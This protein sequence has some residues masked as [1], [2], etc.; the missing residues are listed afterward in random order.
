MLKVMGFSCLLFAQS[1]SYS[2]QPI[3]PRQP[4]SPSALLTQLSIEEKIGQLFIATCII[5]QKKNA[6]IVAYKNYATDIETVKKYINDYHIGGIIFLGMDTVNPQ[7][8][9][10]QEFQQL[11]QIPLFI[12]MDF[13]RG[14]NCGPTMRLYDAPYFPYNMT[15]GALS[16]DQLIY[17]MAAEIAREGKILGVH[18][19]FAPVADVNNN[20]LNPAINDRSFGQ[21]PHKVAQKAIVYM[22]GLQDNG[23]IACAK[24][25]PG[26]GDVSKDSHHELPQVTHDEKRLHA[27]ELYPFKQ[28]IN[29][30]VKMIMTA[31]LE[32]PAL[33]SQPKM[34]AALS[35]NIVTH[36]LKEQL[37]FQGLIV[38]DGLDMTGVTQ[39]GSDQE[40]A[41]QALLAGNDLLLCSRNIPAAVA[42]I[43]KAIEDGR[44]TLQELDA[45]V[46]K[47]LRAKAWVFEQHA[48]DK[49]TAAHNL[50]SDKAAQLKKKLFSQSITIAQDHAKLI[51]LPS[52]S[53]TVITLSKSNDASVF[54]QTLGTLCE[55]KEIIVTDQNRNVLEQIKSHSSDIII[56]NMLNMARFAA[57]NFGITQST[58]D[59]LNVVRSTGKK[60]IFV[61][62][63]NPYSLKNF[64]AQDIVIIGYENDVDAQEAAARIIMGVMPARG[65]LP[66]TC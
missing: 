5:D 56:V 40:I 12:A 22:Q 37:D 44:L 33:D 36:L 14:L 65:T 19:N 53:C 52:T 21:D 6:A 10:T 63:G 49:A 35:K 32:V 30:N 18:I 2:M 27:V 55:V 47:I 64:D 39:Y 24:H 25:F 8:Q 61:L 51:P 13:E 28:L 38:T 11:S 4:F 26:H 16:N 60:V 46:L 1:I 41:L 45:K 50:F 54:A 23:I 20:P 29:Q 31:F 48:K 59:M 42:H 57:Q 7:V 62:F 17:E 58:L 34:P 9:I 15:L 3:S 43:K 66:I